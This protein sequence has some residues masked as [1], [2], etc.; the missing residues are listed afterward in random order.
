LKEKI[1][2]KLRMEMGGNKKKLLWYL[3][4]QVALQNEIKN[5]K[6]TEMG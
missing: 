2:E 5:I 3:P 4:S 1:D 6:N